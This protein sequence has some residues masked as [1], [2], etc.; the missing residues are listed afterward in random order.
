[1]FLAL[2]LMIAVSATALAAENP[3]EYLGGT[4]LPDSANPGSYLVETPALTD[5]V[6][7]TFI[8]EAPNEYYSAEGAFYYEQAVTL[9]APDGNARVFTVSD[10]LAH[11]AQTNPD[12]SFTAS[13]RNVENELVIEPFTGTSGYLSGVTHIEDG[14]PTVFQP[15]EF[16]LWG[17]ECRINDL[18]P[19]E[20]LT[21]GYRGTSLDQTYLEDGDVVHFF[22]NYPAT[23]YGADYAANFIRLVPSAAAVGSIEAQVESQRDYL[24]T[25]PYENDDGTQSQTLQMQVESYE[26]FT[27]PTAVSLYDEN[28]NY[29]TG[30]VSGA[31][32]KVT[33]ADAAI[34]AGSYLLKS[35][36]VLLEDDP[37]EEWIGC[38][39]TQTSGYARV[40]VP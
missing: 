38:L 23:V 1:M 39:F 15:E 5:S 20:K 33:L 29:I 40:I 36:S 21:G 18:V 19:V 24:K 16:D 14:V 6:Q 12:F 30:G 28:G 4:G 25:V 3:G 2:A 11:L 10:L 13:Y 37:N 31:D 34:T 8:M 35:Q 32:G 26:T 9:S 27:V 7:V 22:L 17:W